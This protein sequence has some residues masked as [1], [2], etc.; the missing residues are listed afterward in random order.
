[1]TS[2][3]FLITGAMGCI[4]AWAVRNLVRAGIQTAIFD[5]SDD[6]ARM[7]LIMSEAEIAQVHFI[8]GDITDLASVKRAVSDTG[9]THIIHLAGLQIPF[10]KANPALGA[11]VNVVGTVNVFEAV[12]Q[13][14]EQIRGLTYAS[15]VG[16]LGPDDFYPDKPVAGD[17]PLRPNTLYGV[18]KQANEHTA[19]V[20]WQDWQ[21]GSVGLR[22]YIVYG[23]GRDQGLTS[24]LAKAILAAA[25]NRPFHIK[26]S[27]PVALQYANDVARIFIG[28]ARAGYQGATVC[29]LRN[30]V[31]DVAG[32]TATLRAEAPAA[33]ITFETNSPLP[34]PADLDDRGL[35][36]ILGQVPRTPLSQAIRQDLELFQTLV[37][38]ERID[39]GQ[40]ER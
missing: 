1:M 10:C 24:D 12:R 23:V 19:R 20:Y 9:A 17:V 39:L 11:Q 6:P 27:G 16:A 26:F 18:Y 13:A 40:L 22:P 25:A 21:V 7:R 28:A 14:G 2:E 32:F 36:Q 3:R 4:G 29:N 33:R 38:E 8:R 35:R 5:L 30:D 34:F 31:I 15:S 37:A